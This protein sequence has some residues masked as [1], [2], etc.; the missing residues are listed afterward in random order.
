L[1]R[2]ILFT[3]TAALLCIP[4]RSTLAV[5][6]HSEKALKAAEHFIL[7]HAVPHTIEEAE[8]VERSDRTAGYLMRL[9]PRGY[10]L[11]A[12]DT[13][14]V[15]IKA[16]SFTSDFDSLP[17]AYIDMLCNELDLQGNSAS[18]SAVSGTKDSNASPEKTNHSSWEFLSQPA[19][20]FS[21]SMKNDTPGT[22]LLTT[23]WNQN[24][25]YNKFNPAVGDEY[26]LTGCVQTALAQVMHYHA[27][28][29]SGTGV[30]H[31]SWNGQELSAVMNRPF[32]WDIM[33]DTVSGSVLVYQQ[34]EVAA[35]MRDLGIMNESDFG[36]DGTS[37]YFHIDRFERAFGYAPV[38]TAGIDDSDFF[39][40]IEEEIDEGRPV[41]LSLPGHMTVADG[42]ADDGT[43]RNIHVNLGW[44]GAYDDYYY[45]DQTL[46]AGDY[47]FEP[48]HTIY[49]NIQPC[50]GME[51][52]PYEPETAGNPAEIASEL[53]DLVM[54]DSFTLRIEACDPDGDT[55]TLS[56]ISSSGGIVP[57]LNGNLLTL[58][59]EEND[60]LCEITVT[61]AS[62]DG[63]DEKKFRVLALD[64]PFYMGTQYDIGG[65][66]TDGT[67][68]DEYRA[69][70]EGTV[71]ISGDRGY[72]NQAFYVW[73]KDDADSV[74]LDASDSPVSGELP[75]GF[76]TICASLTHPFTHYYYAFDTDYS[77]YI[78][79]VTAPEL[80]GSVTDVADS[81]GISL[82]TGRDVI[83][84]TADTT[85]TII[86][87]GES[88]NVYGTAGDDHITLES[89]ARAKL[90]HF[91]GNNTITIESDSGGF[92]V[93]RS[94]ARVTFEGNDG[95]LL[96][97]PATRSLQTI[98][99]NDEAFSLTI[100]S[101]AVLLGGQRVTM[102]PASID[103]NG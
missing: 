12:A 98:E 13:I 96:K 64:D 86:H 2:A 80:T 16:Y 72:S 65:T 69:Y 100:E 23:E 26:T 67:A 34:D 4:V 62:L 44:G 17:P 49:Y 84:L 63:M 54:D 6:I 14:R 24:Y 30:F 66:F 11:V 103:G 71:S 70:L 59:P 76:Y 94:G 73:V 32:N 1:F 37:A 51:C 85:D 56:A 43:G 27:H 48:D 101:R 79:S 87:S 81:M 20:A 46:V 8:P 35:L 39:S 31:H 88:V 15:P 83:V 74:V 22:C 50:Q 19:E 29:A 77:G 102:V 38:L 25:P 42:Y 53:P 58:T 82:D 3:I 75:A 18:R 61:A 40:I 57:S 47:A 68:I 89:G 78:L 7:Y 5:P 52:D 92:T 95:T 9:N 10:I 90:T 91:R 21:T 97:I 93:C 60:I 36:T 28:P 41:L 45:L 55:V 33:P 99:F